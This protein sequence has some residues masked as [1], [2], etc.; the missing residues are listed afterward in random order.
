MCF[1]LLSYVMRVGEV[2]HLGEEIGVD[3]YWMDL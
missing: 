2:E 1:G 3:R